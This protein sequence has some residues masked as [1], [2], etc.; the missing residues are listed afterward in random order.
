[1]HSLIQIFVL[2]LST[3]IFT[4][5]TNKNGC[6]NANAVDMS[7]SI[8]LSVSCLESSL[9]NVTQLSENNNISQYQHIFKSI[10][11]QTEQS[12]S[13]LSDT[14]L[15]NGS[16]SSSSYKNYA[17][18][19]AAKM[20]DQSNATFSSNS[21][22]TPMQQISFGQQLLSVN[23]M[24]NKQMQLFDASLFDYSS[25]NTNTNTNTSINNGTSPTKLTKNMS[26]LKLV[27]YGAM[28]YDELSSGN[29]STFTTTVPMLARYFIEF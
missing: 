6:A 8:G 10:K 4:K 5:N 27:E 13:A 16:S 2:I 26:N 23:T 20:N 15:S 21:T 12:N 7:S 17:K 28:I 24:R 11:E 1:M 9:E 22:S 14:L 19:S 3:L 29:L 18:T 25:S